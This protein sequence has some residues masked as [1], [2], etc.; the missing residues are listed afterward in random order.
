MPWGVAAV[1]AGAVASSVIASEA[2]EDAAAAGSKA[3]DRSAQ[4][5]RD[6]ATQAREDVLTH[7]PGAEQ[8]LLEGSR[9]AFDLFSQGISGQQQA[10]REG[11]LA[12][13]QTVSQGLPQIQNALLGIPLDQQA[14]QANAQSILRE[15]VNPFTPRNPFA[16]LQTQN[17]QGGPQPVDAPQ[18]QLGFASD[19]GGIGN[20]AQQATTFG[21]GTDFNTFQ[22][23]LQDQARAIAAAQTTGRI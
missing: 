21:S 7:F 9:G 14:F 1:A 17:F 5:I 4:Q 10:L 6:A 3:A 2:A 20:L 11:N 8:S 12:A 13:Q 22:R 19:P 23:Q 16:H 15:P 18:P